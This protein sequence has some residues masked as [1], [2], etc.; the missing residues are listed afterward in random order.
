MKRIRSHFSKIAHIYDDLRTTDLEPILFIRKKLEHLD[1][2]EAAD[3]GCG[4]GR[5]DVRLFEQLGERLWL[6][7]IDD[8]EKMLQELTK[9]LQKHKITNYKTVRTQARVL[10]LKDNSLDAVITLNAL[11]HFIVL[12]FLGE[13]SRILA[14]MSGS[15]FMVGHGNRTRGPS[16]GRFALGH[17][18]KEKRLSELNELICVP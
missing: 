2:I 17:H 8:S 4:G 16:W 12:D 6:T 7:C 10:P 13:A 15:P 18:E 9:K 1:R 5:Y 3:I 14:V 11:H